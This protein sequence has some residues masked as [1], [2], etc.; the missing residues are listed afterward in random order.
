MAGS[1]EERVERLERLLEQGGHG[2]RQPRVERAGGQGSVVEAWL[3]RPRKPGRPS[4]ARSCRSGRICSS[5]W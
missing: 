5:T 2:D 1:L 3:G 4:P